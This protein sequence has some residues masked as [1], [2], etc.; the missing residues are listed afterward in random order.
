MADKEGLKLSVS[1]IINDSAWCEGK[2]T[3]YRKPELILPLTTNNQLW[4]GAQVPHG[5]LS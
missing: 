2:V 5:I 1:R 3:A 4:A